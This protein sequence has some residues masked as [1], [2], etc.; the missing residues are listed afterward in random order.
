MELEGLDDEVLALGLRLEQRLA[1]HFL[2]SSVETL[3]LEIT[4]TAVVKATANNIALLVHLIPQIDIPERGTPG[5]GA[6]VAR[7]P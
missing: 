5:R 3:K 2:R 4:R 6:A 7:S 1:V